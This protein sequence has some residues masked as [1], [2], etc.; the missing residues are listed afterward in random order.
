MKISNV[1][2]IVF[3]VTLAACTTNHYYDGKYK[4]TVYDGGGLMNMHTEVLTIN[5]DE[6]LDEKFTL[7]DAPA[8]TTKIACKQFEDRI[9]VLEGNGITKILKVTEDGAL[10][11]NAD[12]IFKKIPEDSVVVEKKLKPLIKKKGNKLIFGVEDGK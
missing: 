2:C 11:L 12:V 10:Q 5:G 1:L 4:G 3:L 7:M 9:E 8:G 6:I